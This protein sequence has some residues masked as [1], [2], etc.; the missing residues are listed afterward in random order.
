MHRSNGERDDTQNR[1]DDHSVANREPC[2]NSEHPVPWAARSWDGFG[3]CRNGQ[4]R[5]TTLHGHESVL[6]CAVGRKNVASAAACSD[7]VL[8]APG[9]SL[10]RTRRTY[11]SIS[12]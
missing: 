8:T 4:T 2:T 12:V 5:H 9:V 10:A 7:D 11:T 3:L 1:R 6:T